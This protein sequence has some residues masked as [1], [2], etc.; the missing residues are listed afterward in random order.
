[1]NKKTVITIA[2]ILIIVVV[3]IITNPSKEKHEQA[4]KSIF[5]EYVEEYIN[6]NLRGTGEAREQTA[7]DAIAIIENIVLDNAVQNAVYYKNGFVFSTGNIKL[8][9][10]TKLVSFGIFGKVFVVSSGKNI[11][12]EYYFNEVQL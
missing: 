10:K 8:Y 4:I 1:M 5:K 9:G 2:I 12:E 3:A 6:D 11:L 7:N